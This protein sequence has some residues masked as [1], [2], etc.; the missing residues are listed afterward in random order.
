MKIIGIVPKGYHDREVIL[1]A[2]PG[3]LRMILGNLYST[4]EHPDESFVPGEVINVDAIY[5]QNDSIADVA[6]KLKDLPTTLRAL[7]DILTREVKVLDTPA[8]PAA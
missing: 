7:A 3:E 8:D 2:T 4:T 5:R 6:R 1:Q